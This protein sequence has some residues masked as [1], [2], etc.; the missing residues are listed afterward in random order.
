MTEDGEYFNLKL[1]G[2][3]MNSEPHQTMLFEGLAPGFYRLQTE[4]VTP[5]QEIVELK[6]SVN[7]E[8]GQHYKFNIKKNRRDEYVMRI[9]AIQP[10]ANQ[11]G[12]N[13]PPPPSAGQQSQMSPGF[14]PG[15][16][17]GN[18]PNTQ[19]DD[20]GSTTINGATVRMSFMD[21]AGTGMSVE[22]GPGGASM[23]VSDGQG[24]H[25]S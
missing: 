20:M 5:E 13:M 24:G 21:F 22:A 25:M 8:A 17:P 3:M 18:Q 19:W 7:M 1:D 14:D 11:P 2:R 23:S 12:Q 4:V 15:E 16:H 6:K 10:I 9:F